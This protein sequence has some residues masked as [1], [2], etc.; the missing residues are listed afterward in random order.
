MTENNREKPHIDDEDDDNLEDTPLESIY[1]NP[2]EKEFISTKMIEK[3]LLE[4][5]RRKDAITPKSPAFLKARE[6]I[7]NDLIA[8]EEA[9]QEKD[10]EKI[11]RLKEELERVFNKKEIKEEKIPEEKPA[12]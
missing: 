9:K 11:D 12:N 1:L 4:G 5:A 3:I 6:K 2:K 7:I 8:E 10:T